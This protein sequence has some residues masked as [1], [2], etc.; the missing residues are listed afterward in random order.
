MGHPTAIFLSPPDPNFRCGICLD[1]FDDPVSL[2]HCGHTFCRS[3]LE[4]SLNQ[5]GP[6]CPECRAEIGLG[7]QD[8][9]DDD[10][11]DDEDYEVYVNHVIHPVRVIKSAID[12][13][14]V[15]CGNGRLDEV[16]EP[17]PGG[18]GG[19]DGRRCGGGCDWTGPL[20]S[21]PLHSSTTCPVAKVRCPVPGCGLELPRAAA[22]AH[23][24]SAECVGAAVATR[25][26][27]RLGELLVDLRR[28][29]RRVRRRVGEL[30]EEKEALKARLALESCRRLELQEENA[31]LRQEVCGLRREAREMKRTVRGL[32]VE[33]DHRRRL[34]RNTETPKA[35]AEDAPAVEE[36]EERGGLNER[37]RRRRESSSAVVA[38]AGGGSASSVSPPRSSDDSETAP[39][40]SSS[41]TADGDSGSGSGSERRAKRR[42]KEKKRREKRQ[43]R[44]RGGQGRPPGDD[45]AGE[46]ERSRVRAISSEDFD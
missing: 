6:R 13:S 40:S 33:E 22:R 38:V 4:S 41:A 21:W 30:R 32:L 2:L 8:D 3:C 12:N 29:T 20:S 34:P 7:D 1:V 16:G 15:R 31:M 28:R 25:V 42:R 14:L 19:A 46:G 17:L 24:G 44:R 23:V 26:D 10:D 35:A 36:E 39:S 9:D 43:Q 37:K 18:D 27:E 45:G 11:G 5:T